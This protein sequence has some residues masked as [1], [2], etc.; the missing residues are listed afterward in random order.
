MTETLPPIADLVPH[1]GP[2]CLLDRLIEVEE[3]RLVAEVM[4]SDSSL[5]SR[6]GT[7]GAWVGIEYMAQAVAAWAGSVCALKLRAITRQITDSG[8]SI[9][10]SA[11]A[12]PSWP[13]RRSPFSGLK[14]RVNS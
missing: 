8:S 4:V 9:A 7:V 6:G 10:P 1:K 14:T 11:A 12:A 5:F 2:M 3:E 13:V